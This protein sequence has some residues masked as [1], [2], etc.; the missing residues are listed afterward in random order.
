MRITKIFIQTHGRILFVGLFFAIMLQGC[1]EP[2]IKTNVVVDMGDGTAKCSTDLTTP[3]DKTTL[4]DVGLCQ[5]PM[6]WSGSAKKFWHDEGGKFLPDNTLI[7][8]SA[9]ST[10]CRAYS[11]V[12]GGQACISRIKNVSN[13]VG[14]CY[15]GCVP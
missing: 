4:K 2:L 13:N 8:C 3:L 15:C 5:P 6:A 9:T 12:C 1:T 11:G 10:K 14:T 7:T